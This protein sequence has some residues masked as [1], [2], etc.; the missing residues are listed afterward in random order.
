MVLHNIAEANSISFWGKNSNS[1][2]NMKKTILLFTLC[3]ACILTAKAQNF[4]LIDMEYIMGNIPK[5]QQAVSQLEEL[6]TKYQKEIES[7][8]KDVENLYKEYQQNSAVLSVPLRTQK[9]EEIINKEKEIA[10][11]RLKYFGPEGEMAKKQ[12]DLIEPIE[13]QIYE[14]VKQISLQKGYDAVIDR[15]SASSII[16]ASPRIDISDEILSNL[17]YSN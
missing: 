17:G 3:I 12:N 2:L 7:K 11:L 10:E 1:K 8:A 6:S 16:F 14:I 13:N 5:Y 15:A 9:E 4:A